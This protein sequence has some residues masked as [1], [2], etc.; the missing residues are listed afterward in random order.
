[1]NAIYLE[2]S[3]YQSF[4]RR[5]SKTDISFATCCRFRRLPN[6][7]MMEEV[8]MVLMERDEFE[9][10]EYLDIY[11]IKNLQPCKHLGFHKLKVFDWEL[12]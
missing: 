1:M 9:H 10:S 3:D 11:A 7:T 12:D 8:M 6:Q 5:I 2:V 4:D